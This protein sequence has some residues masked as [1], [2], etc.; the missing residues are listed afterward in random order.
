MSDFDEIKSI[1]DFPSLI[2]YLRKEL[3]WPVDEEQVDDLTFD[4]SPA[5]LGLDDQAGVKIR[6]IKQLR[7]LTGNQPWGIFWIDFEPRK[8][9]VVV[10][11]RILGALVVRKRGG[12]MI[13][14]WPGI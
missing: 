9:P 4:Y 11:R 12:K 8:L 14:A 10:M 13:D 2:R 5:E 7:P 3:G 6:A 1:Q